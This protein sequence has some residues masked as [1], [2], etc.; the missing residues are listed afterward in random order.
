ML[1]LWHAIRDDTQKNYNDATVAHRHPAALGAAAD[2]TAA[3]D[4][5]CSLQMRAS[6]AMCLQVYPCR[7]MKIDHVCDEAYEVV[8]IN[9]QPQV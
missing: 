5:K 6:N 4:D 7:L 9:K 2:D 3:D 8:I 1:T